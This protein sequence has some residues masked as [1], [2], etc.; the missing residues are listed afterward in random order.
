MTDQ[1]L[2][3]EERLQEEAKAFDN[4]IDERISAGHIPDIR[5]AVPCTYFYN[6]SWRH[7]EY[8][9][10]DFGNK[11]SLIRDAI[12]KATPHGDTN[13]RI[14][15]VGC[16]PGYMSL[17]LAREGL[18]VTGLDLSPKCIEVAK[19]IAEED[20]WK[21]KRGNLRYLVDDFLSPSDIEEN[22]FDYIIFVGALHHFPNQEEACLQ[23]RKLLKKNGHI[24]AIEPTRDRVTRGNAIIFN[25][26]QTILSAGGGYY[27]HLKIPSSLDE[28]NE[29]ITNTLNAL[30][31]E[32]SK[33]EK[34]QSVND[35]EAGY[36]EMLT[37]LKES[38]FQ[39]SFKD[40]Y[41][42]FHE[43]IGGLRFD[44]NTNNLLARYIRDVDRE[45]CELGVVQATEFLYVGKV[46]QS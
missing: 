6:N 37:A 22:S 34:V 15:E 42:L 20:P 25:L 32:D 45:L 19:K 9:N 26:I 12:F 44:Q 36:D 33:G 46:P 16:G 1:L 39:V 24:I 21:N 43:L 28:Q 5:R 30:R 38:F 31:Y 40:L 23:C 7:P 4:Q 11:F 41:G 35:N 8:V 10:L 14:L 3:F 17:E 18:D 13:F 27:G 2:S 29:Q